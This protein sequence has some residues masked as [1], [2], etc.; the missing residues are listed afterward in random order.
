MGHG[1]YTGHTRRILEMQR[2]FYFEGDVPVPKSVEMVE[3]S[4]QAL[5]LAVAQW[6]LRSN[7]YANA[8]GG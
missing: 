2:S 7:Y 1:T 4:Q 3:S 6:Q 5:A 8:A